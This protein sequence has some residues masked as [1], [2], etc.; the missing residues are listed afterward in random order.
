M[1]AHRYSPFLRPWVFLGLLVLAACAG[2]PANFEMYPQAVNEGQPLPAD[3]AIVLVGN[4]GP[5]GID[6]LQ[7]DHSGFP[8]INVT[9]INIPPM[10]IA[11]VPISVGVKELSLEDYT[12][13]GRGGGYLPNGMAFGYIAVHTPKIDIN[14]PGLY[15]IATIFA[16]STQ[17]FT[18]EPN[19]VML[20]QFKAAH[21]ELAKLKPVN[22][23][24]PK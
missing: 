5:A 18:A 10:G 11:A 8:V 1:I 21:P 3:K 2:T 7:F 23:S 22:F 24:W 16:G 20:R 15:Y 4:G 9:G 14:T 12:I 6:Y 19:P 17:A 13:S